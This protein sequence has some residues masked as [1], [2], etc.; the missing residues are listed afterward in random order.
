MVDAHNEHDVV[1][2]AIQQS[3]GAAAG[4]EI[5]GQLTAQRLAH[6]SRL[7]GQFAEGELDN[8]GQYGGR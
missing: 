4:A 3:V 7:A 8:S 1:F 2:D 5:P 6:P